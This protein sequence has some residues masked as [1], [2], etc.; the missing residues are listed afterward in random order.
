MEKS[1]K[2]NIEFSQNAPIIL[3][4]YCCCRKNRIDKNILRQNVVKK[5]EVSPFINETGK[6]GLAI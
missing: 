2:T 3:K 5:I 1:Q 6:R 4:M